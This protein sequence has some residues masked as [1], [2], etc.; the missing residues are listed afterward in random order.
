MK[1]EK[2]N[3]PLWPY[4]QVIF[5]SGIQSSCGCYHVC[6][7]RR[8]FL[9]DEISWK[10]TGGRRDQHLCRRL[11]Y[12]LTYLE[13]LKP[14]AIWLNT[15][16]GLHWTSVLYLSYPLSSLVEMLGDTLCLTCRL[17]VSAF[18]LAIWN[19][20]HQKVV[21]RCR[22][23]GGNHWKLFQDKKFLIMFKI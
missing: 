7:M 2:D 9:G 23:Q 11:D 4:S 18:W 15:C 5:R 22:K 14:W 13:F 6:C 17:G 16:R 1:G 20:G 10:V 21:K 3:H 12:V 19:E 8:C